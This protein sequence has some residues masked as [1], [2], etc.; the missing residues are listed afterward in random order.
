MVFGFMKQSGGHINVYSEPGVG[1]TF[2]LYLPRA[3]ADEDVAETAAP[4]PPARGGGE[5]VLAVEDDAALRRVVVRQLK[6]VGYRVIEAENGAQALD[7]AR[8]RARRSL[9]SATSSCPAP[10]TAS[11]WRGR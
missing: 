6:E 2:R 3:A 8:E 4:E 10:S 1:T 9:A 7:A 11:S 5:T